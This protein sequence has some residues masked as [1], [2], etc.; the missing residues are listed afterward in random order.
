LASEFLTNDG[1]WT[2]LTLHTPNTTFQFCAI[3][4]NRSS[5]LR[6]PEEDCYSLPH[7]TKPP[8]VCQET[9]TPLQNNFIILRK[10]VYC[11]GYIFEII[12]SRLTV[13]AYVQGIFHIA[14]VII[15]Q[16]SCILNISHV[17]L[18]LLSNVNIFRP[19]SE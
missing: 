15:F 12:T 10:G 9:F 2:D 8:C 11:H 16:E 19:E 4:V 13:Q 18:W 1:Y 14:E 6:G 5:R 7:G 3:N 17:S